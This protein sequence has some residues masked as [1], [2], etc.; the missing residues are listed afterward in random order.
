MT[1]KEIVS[2]IIGKKNGKD[3]HRV[4]AVA[5]EFDHYSDWVTERNRAGIDIT[6]VS[7]EVIVQ[8][9]NNRAAYDEVL[10]DGRTLRTIFIF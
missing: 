3:V 5:R 1:H 9:H 4:D 8:G 6:D 2:T 10:P 7:A